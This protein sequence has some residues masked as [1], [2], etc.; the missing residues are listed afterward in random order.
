MYVHRYFIGYINLQENS[1][2]LKEMK[3]DID[4]LE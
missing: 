4:N 1:V 3:I 2:T